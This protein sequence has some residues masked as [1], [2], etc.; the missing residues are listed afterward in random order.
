MG[1]S[2]ARARATIRISLSR[3]TTEAEIDAALAIIPTAVARL[4]ELSPAYRKE[5]VAVA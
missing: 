2:P 1:L 4:R 3:L 5:A